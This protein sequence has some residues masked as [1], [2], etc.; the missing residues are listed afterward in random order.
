MLLPSALPCDSS[1][2]APLTRL[3]SSLLLASPPASPPQLSTQTALGSLFT[4]CRS[5][6]SLLVSPAPAAE[7][8]TPPLSHAPPPQLQPRKL[9]LRARKTDGSATAAAAA[10]AAAD[11][12]PAR[13]RIAKRAPAVAPARGLNKRRR[14]DGHDDGSDAEQPYPQQRR[15]QHDGGIFDGRDH[16]SERQLLAPP[17]FEPGTPPSLSLSLPQPQ[18]QQLRPRPQPQPQPPAPR[19]PKRS[20]IAPEVLPLGLERADYHALSPQDY[21]SN[22]PS[23][24]RSSSSSSRREPTAA[25]TTTATETTSGSSNNSTSVN[26]DGTDGG[27]D[28]VIESDGSAWSTEEDRM[29]VELVLE[30]LRLSRSEWQDCARSLGRDR[31]SVGRRWRSLVGNG[32]IGLRRGCSRRPRLS[33]TWR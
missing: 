9:R 17:D 25:A 27:T 22:Y 11:H 32:D 21:N 6:Q 15:Q 18:L 14:A 4:T 8:I 26:G 20:R 30:K 19:T 10:A 28:V 16:E 5:L 2:P 13:K 3:Q 24:D 23:S 29:L 1:Q 12:G 7:P 33:G 31:G